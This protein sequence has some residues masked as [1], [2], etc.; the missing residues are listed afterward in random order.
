MEIYQ[1][2]INS[3][4]PYLIAEVADAHYGSV[5]RAKEMVDLALASGADAVKFQHHLPDE[6]M[7]KVVPQSKNMQEPLYDF[8][9]KNALNIDQHVDIFNYCLN[10][11]IQYLCTPFSLAAALELESN[12]NL[13]L[14]KI[15]S[16]ELTD[17]P[18]LEKIATF[19]KPIIL[20]TGMSLE[21]EIKESYD[22]LIERKVKLILMNC[23]SAYPPNISDLNL[24]YIKIM[25]EKFPKALI[26]H[27]DH[28]NEIFSS[29][30]AMAYGAKVIEKHVTIDEQLLGPDSDV[31]I[32]FS[33]FRQLSEASK[34]IERSIST[35]KIL[36]ES[37]KEIQK[38]ARRSL[39]YLSEFKKGHVIQSGDIWGKRPGTGIPSK[40]YWDY[41]G[42]V[43]K[44]D[45]KKNTLVSDE[46]LL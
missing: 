26:G 2:I 4:K 9:I 14:Y 10:K 25:Q 36:H 11:G 37:E 43:L 17:L 33:Q 16:G 13:P 12:L 42:R 1:Y 21:Y 23:T 41:L 32:T 30:V 45:V 34:I 22:Y 29:I 44:T 46:D 35:E 8:L 5:D 24:G 7:L 3:K 15:G 27:S 39:V 31:S 18:T 38:W 6:E 19:G 28:T 20:S 40:K